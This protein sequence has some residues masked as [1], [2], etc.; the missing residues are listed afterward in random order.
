MPSINLGKIKN[1]FLQK[2]SWERQELNPE[3]LG[4]KRE[5]YLC[6]MPPPIGWVTLNILLALPQTLSQRERKG[7]SRKWC[8]TSPVP[9]NFLF[10]DKKSQKWKINWQ[11]RK[12]GRFQQRG[13]DFR[14]LYI[15]FMF[16]VLYWITLG[17]GR[18]LLDR[19]LRTTMIISLVRLFC[20]T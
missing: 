8:S 16:Q 10:L 12:L 18:S 13:F 2:N 20:K 9:H 3:L 14:T 11:L 7:K 17:W 1:E 4:E 6:A 19:Y 15:K 5:P